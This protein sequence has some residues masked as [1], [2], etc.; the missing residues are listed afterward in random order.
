MRLCNALLISTE[1]KPR[2]SKISMNLKLIDLYAEVIPE[3]SAAGFILG[4]RIE[5]IKSSITELIHWDQESGKSL[6]EAI[7]STSQWLE[8]FES[9]LSINKAARGV[10][11]YFGRG[12]ITL[13]FNENGILY[14][15]Y[16]S[17]GYSGHLWNRIKIGCAL[18]SV[19]DFCELFYDDAD[20]M[21][22]PT[23]GSSISGISFYAEEQSFSCSPD[24][25]IKVISI[26]NWSLK[27]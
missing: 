5:Y 15:I 14:D 20:E 24:Q 21:H 22:Y 1:I 12:A 27:N 6:Q 18:S 10:I 23:E 4:Q 2:Q 26:H 16:V 25:I 11:L 13:H 9:D 19:Q 8:V 3:K 7:Y 17:E